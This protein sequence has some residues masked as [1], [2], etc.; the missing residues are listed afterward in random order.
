MT[1]IRAFVGHSFAPDDKAI[2]RKF[3]DC[4]EEVRRLNPNF[5]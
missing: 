1:E 3:L 2:V 4:F 5:T